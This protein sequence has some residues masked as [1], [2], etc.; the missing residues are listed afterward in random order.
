MNT[1]RN[2][3]IARLPKRIR[4]QLN[5][6]LE[7][8]ESARQLVEWLNSQPQVQEALQ[9]RFAGRPISEQNLC[10]WKQGGYQDWLQHQQ[11]SD[12]VQRLTEQAQDLEAD[13][14]DQPVSDRFATLM[15]VELVRVSEALLKETADPRERWQR[16]REVLHELA[17]LRRDDQQA[18]RLQ[19]ELERWEWEADQLERQDGERQIK[20][21]KDRVLAPIF[22]TMQARTF[23]PLFAAGD[24][25]WDIAAFIA[26]VQHG[27]EQGYLSR[28]GPS[29]KPSPA[30][31][32]PDQAKSN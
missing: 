25:G 28:P 20:E 13:A 3:K 8:G 30:P 12:L 29:P 27:L 1:A 5:C 24:E 21:A 26:E 19:V 22:A 18:V 4:H 6:R 15:A 7:E 10:E 16:L 17:Q 2:G 11:D 9:G 23:A 31:V 32:P 14:D